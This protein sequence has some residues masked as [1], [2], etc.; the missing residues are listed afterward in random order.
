MSAHLRLDVSVNRAVQVLRIQ[1]ECELLP[2]EQGTSPAARIVEPSLTGR[3]QGRVHIPFIENAFW[4]VLHEI[5]G[6][7]LP[8]ACAVDDQGNILQVSEPPGLNSGRPS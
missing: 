8:V 1:I 3:I 2:P 5:G 7:A 4:Q 6:K